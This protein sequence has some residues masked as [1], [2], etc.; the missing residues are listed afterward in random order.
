M[1]ILFSGKWRQLPKSKVSARDRIDAAEAVQPVNGAVS[2]L[3]SKTLAK[4]TQFW[5]RSRTQT[6]LRLVK[7]SAKLSPT[8]VNFGGLGPG[9]GA[10]STAG[11]AGAARRCSTAS[12]GSPAS[13]SSPERWPRL[14]GAGRRAVILLAK[15][16]RNCQVPLSYRKFSCS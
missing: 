12:L 1:Y 7:L 11:G 5:T 4:H 13:S 2:N 9:C 6:S 8:R 14:C 15:H 3:Q 16:G 10:Q